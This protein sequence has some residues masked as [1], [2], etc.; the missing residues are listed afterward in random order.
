MIPSPKSSP[1]RNNSNKNAEHFNCEL[2]GSNKSV[3]GTDSFKRNQTLQFTRPLQS[4]QSSGIKTN[5]FLIGKWKFDKLIGK[6]SYAKV[7]TA[8]HVDTNQQV[9]V[10]YMNTSKLNE[11][12][13]QKLKMEVEIMKNMKK[14]KNIIDFV[15]VIV[16]NNHIYLVTELCKGGDLHDYIKNNKKLEETKLK[17][18]TRQLFDGLNFLHENNIIHRDLKPQN[19]L[20]N[21]TSDNPVLKICD[22]GFS[23]YFKEEN[24]TE[25]LCGSPLYMAPEILRGQKYDAKV[26]LWSFGV[27]CYQMACGKVPYGGINYIELLRN[28]DKY[29]LT[30]PNNVTIAD[31][32]KDLVTKLMQKE[33]KNRID[34]KTLF[35]HPII[36]YELSDVRTS[37]TPQ[38]I[39]QT[40]D[41]DIVEKPGIPIPIPREM[42]N[43]IRQ[44]PLNNS[45]LH[46]PSSNLLTGPNLDIPMSPPNKSPFNAFS[47]KLETS[48]SKVNLT[49][50][51]PVTIPEMNMSSSS[52]NKFSKGQNACG[53]LSPFYRTYNQ[54]SADCKSYSTTF[55]PIEIPKPL[56]FNSPSNYGMNNHI[57]CKTLLDDC[58]TM[59]KR[60]KI[61]CFC[62]KYYLH[63]SQFEQ[64]VNKINDCK[65]CSLLL[66]IKALENDEYMIN[67]LCARSLC[68]CDHQIKIDVYKNTA[69]KRFIN[70]SKMIETMGK[71]I[72]ETI[73]VV[74]VEKLMF[75]CA[76]ELSID[77]VMDKSFMGYSSLSFSSIFVRSCPDFSK[78]TNEKILNCQYA[79]EICMLLLNQNIDNH[80]K[81]LLTS[82]INTIR[83]IQ[84]FM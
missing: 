14:H 39:N 19:I 12:I 35:V 82:C 24:L 81:K 53:T 74:C 40:E 16:T 37:P 55:S 57:L 15:E 69:I 61:M 34:Y 11:K 49:T 25:T 76:L 71:E 18:F 60:T 6:G 26:D 28:I 22:F 70:Y 66:F 8:H 75:D 83:K 51:K 29:P 46:S 38:V 4:L 65:A 7:Y 47:P 9:A 78:I 20:L 21:D 43:T 30:F 50:T 3:Q 33:P 10:K 5:D 80:D 63:K 41:F 79:I 45:V 62:G 73:D 36:G 59:Q 84:E 68:F 72:P 67:R 44:Q 13:K 52:K 42:T 56:Q 1:S 54:H 58:E 32:Y 64:T 23:C 27:I 17:N 77:T 31:S 2:L 48:I